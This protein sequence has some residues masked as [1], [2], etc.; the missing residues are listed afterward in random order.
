VIVNGR[1]QYEDGKLMVERGAGRFLA[2]EVA[3]TAQP[4]PAA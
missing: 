3:R 1:V 4:L 2:R